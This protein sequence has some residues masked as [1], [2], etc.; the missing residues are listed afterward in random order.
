MDILLA[1]DFSA[2]PVGR[3]KS[4]G[5]YTAEHFREDMLV[6]CM[7]AATLASP[8]TIDLT[9]VECLCAHFRE[10]AFAGL[11]RHHGMGYSYI[12]PRLKF[13][14]LGPDS[15]W[16]STIEDLWQL[17]R[18]E[19]HRRR[20]FYDRHAREI[21]GDWHFWVCYAAEDVLDVMQRIVKFDKLDTDAYTH[22]N[23]MEEDGI[24]EDLR[25]ALWRLHYEA[26]EQPRHHDHKWDEF[27]QY[28]KNVM[29]T[30]YYEQ[31][32]GILVNTYMRSPHMP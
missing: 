26:A 5:Q 25:A 7:R 32:S 6:G 30:R 12:H 2:V 18:E 27:A 14:P 11:T 19:T 16:K 1:K 22:E 24:T 13:E 29:E 15:H 3:Y 8:V 10:E 31:G 4:D 17:V 9:D 21:V 28:I 23:S 20:R